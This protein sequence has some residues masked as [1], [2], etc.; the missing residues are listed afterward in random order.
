MTAL[1]PTLEVFFTGRLINEKG[2]SS[3]T[4]NAYRDTFRPGF[5]S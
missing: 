4:I 2:A 1:A 5:R 3:H